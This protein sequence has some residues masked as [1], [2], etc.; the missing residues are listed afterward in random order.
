MT[1]TA[2]TVRA[3]TEDLKVR[4]SARV[5]RLVDK[6][7]GLLPETPRASFSPAHG[8]CSAGSVASGGFQR[9]RKVVDVTE[10]LPRAIAEQNMG[11]DGTE[12]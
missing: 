5:Y 7:G 1:R 10:E 4:A 12:D 8:S 2:R 9:D 6:A 11:W 3:V